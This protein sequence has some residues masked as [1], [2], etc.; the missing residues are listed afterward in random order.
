[1]KLSKLEERMESLKSYLE[2]LKCCTSQKRLVEVQESIKITEIEIIELE[3]K[4]KVK[5]EEL[6]VKLE[7]KLLLLTPSKNQLKNLYNVSN[8]KIR[9]RM[10]KRLLREERFKDYA[11][12][13]S[14][15]K[16]ELFK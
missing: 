7:R 13:S 14:S 2:M 3:E 16:K 5:R 8:C 10:V 1:M 11:F 15:V 12:K 9:C 4:I 6:K